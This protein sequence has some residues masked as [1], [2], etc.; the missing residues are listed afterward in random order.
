[1]KHPYLLVRLI[2]AVGV[3][4]LGLEVARV[5]LDEVLCAESI[6]FMFTTI[7]HECLP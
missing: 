3:A 5:L 7:Q 6:S 2:G 1:M 4:D